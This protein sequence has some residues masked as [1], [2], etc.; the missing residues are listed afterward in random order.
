MVLTLQLQIVLELLSWM[1]SLPGEIARH[2]ILQA[3]PAVTGEWPDLHPNLIKAM[4]TLGVESLYA[5]QGRAIELAQS[6]RHVVYVSSSPLNKSA[7]YNLSILDAIL[8]DNS[9]RALY[10]FP[11]PALAEN[12]LSELVQLVEAA[13]ETIGTFAYDLTTNS[14]DWAK[15]RQDGRIIIS[16]METLHSSILLGHSRWEDFFKGLRYIVIDEIHHYHGITGAHLS[17]ILRRL[18]RICRF[19]GSDPVFFCCSPYLENS[20]ELAEK[21]TGSSVELVVD[22]SSPAGEAHIVV[23]NAPMLNPRNN[24]RRPP[25]LETGRIAA[26]ALAN[27]IGTVIF[28]QSQSNVETLFAYL[29]GDLERRGHKTDFITSYSGEFNPGTL[30]CIKNGLESEEIRGLVTTNALDLGFSLAPLTLT[31]LHGLPGNTAM[32]HEQIAFARQQSG[33]SMGVLVASSSPTDQFL[34]SC[35]SFFFNE[36]YQKTIVD[37]DNPYILL[38]HLRCSSFELPFKENELFGHRSISEIQEYLASTGMCDN[39]GQCLRWNLEAAPSTGLT[40]ES[41]SADYYVILDVTENT[42]PRVVGHI[43]CTAAP[44]LLY[45][46]AIFSQN[47]QSFEVLE[48][49]RVEMRALVRR[50]TAEYHTQAYP[51]V[52]VE[53]EN[54]LNSGDTSSWGNGKISIRLRSFKKIQIATHENAGYGYIDL[55]EEQLCTTLCHMT[56]PDDSAWYSWEENQQ[57]VSLTALA[58]L[59]GVVAPLFLMCDRN[60]LLLL[61]R[62]RNQDKPGIFIADN[63]PGGIGLAKA[64]WEM[65]RKLLE[66]A[67]E[68]LLLCPCQQ[69]CTSCIGSDRPLIDTKDFVEQLLK[70]LLGKNTEGKK[71][72]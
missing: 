13:E 34:A 51:I 20:L 1:N 36:T 41:A 28:A 12:R 56:L 45:P 3:R 15:I 23:Y 72:D 27:D 42:H 59:M 38:R 49:D 53:L 58:Y 64:V 40:L 30:S 61:G 9:A 8:K 18:M 46:Q 43:D 7:C 66:V 69:G 60:D 6:L 35:P 67:L 22:E 37:P 63:V 29:A 10:L 32:A 71:E 14:A 2:E 65:D 11:T 21:L 47:G 55:P 39:D 31:I 57:N 70:E 54:T 33:V 26:E 48:L 17:N 52:S 5:D 68:M 50:V 19:Y 62:I 16:N 25:I 24:V 4:K 44:S